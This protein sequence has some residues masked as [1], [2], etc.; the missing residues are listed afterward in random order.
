MMSLWYL[1]VH[2][3]TLGAQPFP[4]LGIMLSFGAFAFVLFIITAVKRI[5]DNK[6][7]HILW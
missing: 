5:L 1:Y 6:N 2:G 3:T 7:Q 4:Y